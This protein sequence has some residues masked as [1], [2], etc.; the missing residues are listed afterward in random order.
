MSAFAL[1]IF[2]ASVV[3]YGV[4]YSVRSRSAAITTD[5]W[6]TFYF[7][8]AQNFLFLPISYSSL[9]A[10]LIGDVYYDYV[11]GVDLVVWLSL[12]G[13]GFFIAG[14]ISGW[15][16]SRPLPGF[17]SLRYV[18]EGFWLRRF[19]PWYGLGLLTF[20]AVILASQGI[21]F[22]QARLAV[23]ENP[24]LQPLNNLLNA[25]AQLFVLVSLFHLFKRPGMM[26]WLAFILTL[27]ASFYGGTRSASVWP[28][29]L[30]GSVLMHVGRV[31][32]VLPAL[33]ALAILIV[34]AIAYGQ[35]RNDNAVDLESGGGFFQELLFGGHLTEQRDF[36]WVYSVW[37]HTFL[38]GKSIWAG[39]IGFV[40][41][42][43]SDFRQEWGWGRYTARAAGFDPATFSGF[44]LPLFGEAYFNFSW[45]GI[46]C[47]GFALGWVT[48]RLSNMI[49]IAAQSW[50]THRGQ[51]LCI[52]ATAAIYLNLLQ[53]GLVSVTI[54]VV[55]VQVAI[56]AS[57]LVFV[58]R[59]RRQV[60]SLSRT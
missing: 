6:I 35:F 26:S 53:L 8:L 51:A 28:I 31:K 19:A 60:P 10:L 55:Y 24:S 3:S 54:F 16:S 15:R 13:A 2:L 39:L 45:P 48:F 11:A 56:L 7:V 57:G 5:V 21:G 23:M 44:R 49:E 47:V 20:F 37:D 17:E 42:S 46:A 22:G 29:L 50:R 58:R 41:S 4:Y 12:L 25:C 59:R 1:I 52:A 9:N 36:A 18:V 43:M 27:I 32:R 34:F 14:A 40:P 33:S 30:G 38:W